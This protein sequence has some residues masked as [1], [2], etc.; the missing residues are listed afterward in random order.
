MIRKNCNPD[1]EHSGVFEWQ[2]DKD[3]AAEDIVGHIEWLDT[4][5]KKL[6]KKIRDQIDGE[7]FVVVLPNTGETGALHIAEAIM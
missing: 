2:P 1:G 5:M 6:L 4:E 3:G 7:E